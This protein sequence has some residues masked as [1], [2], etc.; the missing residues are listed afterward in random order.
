MK[1]VAWIKYGNPSDALGIMEAETPVPKKNEVL[2]KV[3]STAVTVGDARLRASNVPVGFWVPTRLIF[4]LFKPRHKTP[5]MHFSGTVEGLGKEVESFDIGD[6]VFGSSGMRFGANAEYMCLPETAAIIKK[7][8]EIDHDDAVACI[9]G[10]Q[11]AI[12]FLKNTA[13]LGPGQNILVNGASGAVGTASIQ[14]AKYLGADVTAV[15]STENIDLVKSLGAD[16]AIDYTGENL[17]AGEETYDFI[18]DAVGN[19]PL[20]RG[21]NL[22]KEQGKLISINVGLFATLSAAWNSKLIVGVARESKADLQFLK[23]LVMK[24]DFK[25]VIDRVYPLD[26]IAEAHEYVDR[27]HKKGNVVIA[28]AT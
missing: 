9:F 12:H 5:G 24:G 27:G 21:K 14:L 6:R 26:K 23:E 15:C 20:S 22:L 4:G 16:K 25:P 8:D 7:P 2:I 17:E 10:G 1:A 28:V 3:H 13:K 11:T 18:L 19:I